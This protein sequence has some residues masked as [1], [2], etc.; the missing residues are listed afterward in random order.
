[1]SKAKSPRLLVVDD[2]GESLDLLCGVLGEYGYQVVTAPGGREALHTA[3]ERQPD[4]VLLDVNMPGMDGFEVC[5]RFK[6]S[7][8]LRDVP[9]IFLTGSAEA[10]D[11]VRGF[12]M[13][14]VDYVTKPFNLAE[15]LSRVETHLEL[16][17]ARLKLQELATKLS[18]YLAPP[19]YD[20]IFSGERDV[21][22]ETRRKPLTVFFSDIVGFTARTEELE[23]LELTLWLNGYLDEMAQIALQYGGT[24]DKFIGDAVMVFFGDPNSSGL[25][26][27][28]VRCVKMGL[29][30]LDAARRRDI[31]IRI[32]IHSG[33]CS[34]GNFGSERQMDYTIIGKVVN[35]ASRLQG[36][37]EGGRLL[38]SETT[39]ILIGDDFLCDPRGPLELRGVHH[40]LMTY[41]VLAP[42]PRS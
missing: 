18:R 21:R 9:I 27:D 8:F 22:I 4:L 10:K 15:L 23:D 19:V 25:Q 42:K 24:L 5:L 14:A 26:E 31:D 37:S 34:V 3:L 6:Q 11:V 35:V 2:S 29:T 16:R 17:L 41:W 33:E 36:L 12:S 20:S 28:A 13:G 40:R 38:I 39:R 1:M 32:G 30:M 7:P